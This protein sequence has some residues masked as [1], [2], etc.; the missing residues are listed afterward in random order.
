MLL[1]RDG[2]SVRD[3]LDNCPEYMNGDQSDVDGDGI[4]KL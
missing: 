3:S 4:G 2:D 1:F